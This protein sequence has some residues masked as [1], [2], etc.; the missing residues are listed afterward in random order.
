M[1]NHQ[2]DRKGFGQKKE[3]RAKTIKSIEIKEE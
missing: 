2:N 3:D 1:K